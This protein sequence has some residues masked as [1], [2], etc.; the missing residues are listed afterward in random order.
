MNDRIKACRYT[1]FAGVMLF[2]TAHAE[3]GFLW[4]P[5]S[6]IFGIE[7][8]ACCSRYLTANC[9]VGIDYLFPRGIEVRAAADG[10]VRRVDDETPTNQRRPKFPYGNHIRI[11][12][13]NGYETRYAHLLPDAEVT[14]GQVVHAGDLL[15]HS[16]NTG[17][18]TGNHLHFEVRDPQN[19]AVDPYSGSIIY[20]DGDPMDYGTSCGSNTLW[21]VCPPTPAPPAPPPDADGDGFTVAQGDCDDSNRDVR[22]SAMETCNTID[23]DCNGT[24]DD[25]WHAGL[26]IDLDRPCTVGVGTCAS[27]GTWICAP[28]GRATVCSVDPLP[29]QPES[30]NGLDDDCDDVADEDWRIGL[31]TDLGQPCSITW[32]TCRGSMTGTWVCAPDGRAVVCDAPTPSGTPAQPESCNSLDDDCDGFVDN[33]ETMVLSAS[34]MMRRYPSITW[35][36]VD[37][38][39]AVV[40][41]ECLPGPCAVSLQRLDG[42]GNPIGVPMTVAGTEHSRSFGMSIVW[43]GDGYGVIWLQTPVGGSEWTYELAFLRFGTDG[44][45][46]EPATSISAGPWTFEGSMAYIQ[47]R[48]RIA[49]RGAEGYTVA[50]YGYV[51]S[52]NT[53]TLLHLTRSGD[54]TGDPLPVLERPDEFEVPFDQF[55]LAAAG[56]R[57][58]VVWTERDSP[59]YPDLAVGAWDGAIANRVTLAPRFAGWRFGM[60]VSCAGATECRIRSL[61][62]LDRDTWMETW[63]LDLTAMTATTV[64]T[65]SYDRRSSDAVMSCAGDRCSVAASDVATGPPE[66]S[67]DLGIFSDGVLPTTAWQRSLSGVD[68]TCTFDIARGRDAVVVAWSVASYIAW[69][70][71]A[72]LVVT[73]LCP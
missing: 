47:S 58:V 54:I 34:D 7:C 31:T 64:P 26:S 27:T 66:R 5:S 41:T 19:H 22:P 12:H 45:I 55:A 4:Y 65:A 13:A 53:I 69:M 68:G 51:A 28:D 61:L 25:P 17:F 33:L 2:G 71:S 32:D 3:E 70:P 57:D 38:Q 52:A 62:S 37:N 23:D 1:L 67:M 46:V 15:G 50:V 29:P 18:S 9:H 16:D 20:L 24:P 21:V 6:R 43:D 14:D 8:G 59:W 39:F 44:V 36:D 73:K 63:D 30:C 35:N 40:W 48:V 56:T 11:V 60:N 72:Q 49:A 42:T 10:V